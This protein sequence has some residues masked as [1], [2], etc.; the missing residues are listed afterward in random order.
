[1]GR[2]YRCLL[3]SSYTYSGFPKDNNIS[4]WFWHFSWVLRS[5]IKAMKRAHDRMEPWGRQYSRAIFH[6]NSTNTLVL[7]V[8][9]CRKSSNISVPAHPW[10]LSYE[11]NWAIIVYHMHVLNQRRLRYVLLVLWTP[12]PKLC[13]KMLTWSIV[14]I[15]A[16]KL[17]YSRAMRRVPSS[18]R[19]RSGWEVKHLVSE[20]YGHFFM[21]SLLLKLFF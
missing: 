13:T 11:A 4:I 7:I 3:G 10:L 17:A 8:H 20:P 1:M 12:S 19:K 15:P 21:H 18:T 6:E 16:L 2:A 14:D 5:F 9:S